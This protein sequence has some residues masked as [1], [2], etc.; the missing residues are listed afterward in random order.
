MARD[1]RAGQ[2]R[3]YNIE[4][5]PPSIIHPEVLEKSTKVVVAC[6]ASPSRG[7]EW[8]LVI[9]YRLDEE[10]GD[11]VYDLD[12]FVT[13]LDTDSGTPAASGVF[14]YHGK[15]EGRNIEADFDRREDLTAAV[16]ELREQVET[17]TYR[18]EDA[19]QDVINAM[20]YMV[21]QFDRALASM[22]N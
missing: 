11:K 19:D 9:P 2:V 17:G 12:P 6:S 7:R 22:E 5:F 15:F 1:V 21:G 20:D 13:Y 4:E 18:L 16:T 3:I 10:A 14:V 8:L